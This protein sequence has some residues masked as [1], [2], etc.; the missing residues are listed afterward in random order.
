MICRRSFRASLSCS[1]SEEPSVVAMG[2]SARTVHL[3][4]FI[5]NCSFDCVIAMDLQA[6]CHAVAAHDIRTIFALRDAMH[7][8]L[9]ERLRTHGRIADAHHGRQ[10][11]SISPSCKIPRHYETHPS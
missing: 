10:T 2:T 4:R 5:F 6:I 8:E 1:S 3:K 9:C 7:I 11:P